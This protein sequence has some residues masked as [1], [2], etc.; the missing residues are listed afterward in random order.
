MANKLNQ[1]STYQTPTNQKISLW[2]R[3]HL[4]STLLLGLS[5][6]VAC[7]LIILFSASN[8]D[9]DIVERQLVRIGFAAVG[10]LLF[11]QISPDKYRLWTPWLYGVTIVLL[12]AVLAIGHIGKG[13]Q[14]WLNLGVVHFQ[15]SEV[16]KLALPMMLAWY[17]REKQLPP[18]T[19]QLLIASFLILLPVGLIAVQP[20]LGTAVLVAAAGASVMLLAGIRFKMLVILLTIVVVATPFLW[21]HLHDYQRQRVLTFINPERD[22]LGSG[23][24]IIQSKIA[25]GSGGLYGK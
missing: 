11:A 10:M 17:F 25:I 15:P 1:W 3:S 4:D 20:D 9:Y 2:R 22:P 18:T 14:R 19:F 6:L 7:G 23:Y 12:L 13:A 24:H 16:M 8:G 21:H 5:A